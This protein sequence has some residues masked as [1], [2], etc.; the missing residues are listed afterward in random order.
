MAKA[1]PAPRRGTSRAWPRPRSRSALSLAT[2]GP[3]LR[4]PGRSHRP[5]AARRAARGSAGPEG[6][7]AAAGLAGRTAGVA[8]PPAGPGLQSAPRCGGAER[9]RPAG[10][11]SRAGDNQRVTLP[12]PG[13]AGLKS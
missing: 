13:G 3:A 7:T 11:D 1:A 4:E 6:A 9:G 12:L 8:A 2:R 10:G 5:R